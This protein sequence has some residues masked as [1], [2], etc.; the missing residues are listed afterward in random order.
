MRRAKRERVAL[1]VTD[2]QPVGRAERLID[3]LQPR[4]QHGHLLVGQQRVSLAI[5]GVG[6]R[7]GV[8][9]ELVRPFEDLPVPERH[10]AN[11]RMLLVRGEPACLERHEPLGGRAI[12]TVARADDVIHE[13]ALI[14]GQRE[15][16]RR[17]KWRV[18]RHQVVM[19]ELDYLTGASKPVGRLSVPQR[20]QY[21]AMRAEKDSDLR[22]LP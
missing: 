3:V 9:A 4:R 17:R 8:L 18:S 10:L 20:D 14:V 22:V 6:M 7:L 21:V 15:P 11:T 2:G 12:G 1:L 16:A 5:D 19:V 13:V